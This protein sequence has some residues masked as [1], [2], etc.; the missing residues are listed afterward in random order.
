MP[1]V[2]LFFFLLCGCTAYSALNFSIGPE[3]YHFK[4]TRIGGTWQNGF[5][6]GGRATFERKCPWSWYLGADALIAQGSLRGKNSANLNLRSTLTDKIYEG[7]LGFMFQMPGK[8]CRF[9]LPFVGYGS[10]HETNDFKSPSPLPFTFIDTF[11]YV[12]VGFLSGFNITPLLSIGINFKA[13]FMLNAHSQ[14]TDD[15][16]FDEI[17]LKIKDEINTRLELP[18]TWTF[19]R[20][21]LSSFFRFAPFYE[22]R[23]FGG[24]EGFPFDFIDTEFHLIGG[25][26]QLGLTY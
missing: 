22:Y 7:R 19:Y 18:L 26:F 15:P 21:C 17:S 3:I 4:R 6:S 2:F 14:V 11:Q 1:R 12:P 9:F 25:S 16:L 20:G 5:I 23:H 10:F 8:R 13:E 24:Q